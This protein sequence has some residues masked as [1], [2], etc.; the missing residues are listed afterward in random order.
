MKVGGECTFSE[1]SNKKITYY[2]TFDNPAPFLSCEC[3]IKGI[4]LY[5]YL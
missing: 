3:Q 2:G 4:L 1:G 5:I